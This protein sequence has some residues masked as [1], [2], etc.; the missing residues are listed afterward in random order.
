MLTLTVDVEQYGDPSQSVRFL[1]A[2]EPLLDAFARTESKVTFFV[3]GELVPYCTD[4]LREVKQHG[5]EVAL[6]GHTHRFLDRMTPSDFKNELKM[7]RQQIEDVLG[8]PPIGFRAPYFSLT[9]DSLW[10]P[11]LLAEAGF[12]YSSSVLP[13]WN[14]QA[15]FPQAP[16][17]PFIWPSGLIEFPA[18]TFGVG[19]LRLPVIGGAY[20]R[21]SPMML[22]FAARYQASKQFGA[23]TYCHPYDFD[24]DEP[25]KRR[26]EDSWFFSRLLFL[27]RDIMLKRILKVTTPGSKSL[28]SLVLNSELVRALATWPTKNSGQ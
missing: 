28:G 8:E 24:H 16:R 25:F 23:W 17:H 9:E 20:L 12:L 22:V 10:A 11:D 26:E 5:H 6:H 13:A 15:G 21:L 18:P 7:G 1:R 19:P 27:R 3:V 2:L 4:L 14:P